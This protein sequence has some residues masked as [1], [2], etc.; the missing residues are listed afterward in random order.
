MANDPTNLLLASLSS[1]DLKLLAPP[2]CSFCVA[3]AR[4]I[5]PMTRCVAGG[6]ALERGNDRSGDGRTGRGDR[7]RYVVTRFE[8]N[9]V[10]GESKWP[11]M[12]TD[13]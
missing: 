12:A 8:Q 1:S 9:L 6:Y 2:V 13:G 3:I 5:F 10:L 7:R 4:A 11:E